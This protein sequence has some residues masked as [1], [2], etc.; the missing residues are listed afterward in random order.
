VDELVQ[1]CLSGVQK[2][3][4]PGLTTMLSVEIQQFLV[5]HDC[6]RDRFP[7]RNRGTL[8][9]TDDDLLQRIPFVVSVDNGVVSSVLQ[10]SISDTVFGNWT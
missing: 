4:G 7:G 9:N 2:L 8:H 3:L 6:R 1:V 5:M 10:D